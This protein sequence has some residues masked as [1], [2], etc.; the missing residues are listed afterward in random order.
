MGAYDY[1]RRR[2]PCGVLYRDSALE[3]HGGQFRNFA[4]GVVAA[5]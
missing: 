5:Q 1:R 3:F 2:D 4:Q